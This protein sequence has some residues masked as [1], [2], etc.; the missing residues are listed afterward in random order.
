MAKPAR[1]LPDDTQPRIRLLVEQSQPDPNRPRLDPEIERRF[2]RVD[3]EAAA[4]YAS[5]EETTFRLGR[6]AGEEDESRVWP[7]DED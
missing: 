6:L 5:M 1:R 3:A 2:A 7:P 4:C